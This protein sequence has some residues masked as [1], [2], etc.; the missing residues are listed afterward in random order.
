MNNFSI[1]ATE[2]LEN[3]RSFAVENHFVVATTLLGELERLRGARQFPKVQ[4]L[5]YLRIFFELML[6]TELLQMNLWA[7]RHR[8]ERP[9]FKNL[10]DKCNAADGEN[11]KAE[12]VWAEKYSRAPY[13]YLTKHLEFDISKNDYELDKKA[14]DGVLLGIRGALKNRTA[15]SSIS[16]EQR[17][18]V[19]AF[20]KLKHGFVVLDLPTVTGGTGSKVGIFAG[21]GA[22]QLKD[23]T[24][25]LAAAKRRVGTIESIMNT[26]KNLLG[27]VLDEYKREQTLS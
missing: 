6:S 23:L 8:K 4:K 27:L 2:Y 20:N 3:Y 22:S 12:L 16:R 7:V 13:E 10:L 26:T 18:L 24:V 11:A 17:V 25:N 15:T 21:K 9:H 5:L 1:S 19:K 14:L